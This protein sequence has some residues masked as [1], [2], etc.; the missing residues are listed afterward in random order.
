MIKATSDKRLPTLVWWLRPERKSSI[1]T[2]N[3]FHAVFGTL[4]NMPEHVYLTPVPDSTSE[5]TAFSSRNIP[6]QV[7]VSRTT[8]CTHFLL[9][10]FPVKNSYT[11][12]NHTLSASARS[13]KHMCWLPAKSNRCASA[14]CLGRSP[15]VVAR[16]TCAIYNTGS[17]R[18]IP[19][20]IVTH[21]HANTISSHVH[22]FI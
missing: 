14:A 9:S 15:K 17:R 1:H 12:C 5:P 7:V 22:A 4:L 21:C 13:T 11:Q 8:L 6:S 16:N 18:K 10:V 19:D 3:D 2:L 20:T